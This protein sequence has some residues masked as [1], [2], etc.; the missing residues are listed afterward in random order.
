AKSE[1]DLRWAGWS[2]RMARVVGRTLADIDR[3]TLACTIVLLAVL[4]A[5]TLVLRFGVT[6]FHIADAFLRTVSILATGAALG[7]QGDYT[8]SPGLQ[9]FV[10]ILRIVGAVL[11]AAFTAIVTNYLLRA[12][13][14][15]AFE[16]RR[17]PDGGHIV[18]CGLGSIGFLVIEELLRYDERVVVI[19]RDPANRLVNTTRRLGVPVIIGDAGVAEVMRQAR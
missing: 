8:D 7:E 16:V 17:I 3:A 5:S 6:K 1:A 11:M 18:V 19:E 10:S 9:V 2:R 14:G 4:I 13:L 15:G 12:R